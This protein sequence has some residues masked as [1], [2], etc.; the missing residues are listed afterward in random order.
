MLLVTT[1]LIQVRMF[2]YKAKKCNGLKVSVVPTRAAADSLRAMHS[3]N[4]RC[5]LWTA[6]A[7]CRQTGTV[8]E[9]LFAATAAAAASTTNTSAAATTNTATTTTTTTT[10]CLMPYYCLTV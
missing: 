6:L 7:V 10:T 2:C 4:V 3:Q 1:L 9:G 8:L 5:L